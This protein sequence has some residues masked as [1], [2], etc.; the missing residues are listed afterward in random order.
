MAMPTL[1]YELLIHLYKYLHGWISSIRREA[2]LQL[3]R[4]QA[5]KRWAEVSPADWY[6]D[7]LTGHPRTKVLM[8]TERR[9]GQW[10]LI[11]ERSDQKPSGD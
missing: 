8:E 2:G 7:R 5:F 11:M 6:E 10:A 9:Q 4:I 3:W 1:I